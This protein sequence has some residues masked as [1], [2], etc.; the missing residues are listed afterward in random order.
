MDAKT[1]VLVAK[2]EKARIN[3]TRKLLDEIPNIT[4]NKI[5]SHWDSLD[6]NS[7]KD[8][9]RIKI[10]DFMSHFET[11]EFADCKLEIFIHNLVERAF[12]GKPWLTWVCFACEHFPEFDDSQSH[13]MHVT[14]EHV[15]IHLSPEL[16]SLQPIFDKDQW[17]KMFEMIGRCSWKPLEYLLLLKCLRFERNHE[18]MVLKKL[19][20]IG[21]CWMILSVQ[22]L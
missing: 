2:K 9:L 1:L 21:L 4:R 14:F 10:D 19:L 18:G 6:L 5:Y 7:K 8:F 3:V 17:A 20:K 22:T 11:P 16:M 15:G 12:V 13:M